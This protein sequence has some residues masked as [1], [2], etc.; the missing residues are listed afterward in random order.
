MAS[1]RIA[2][3]SGGVKLWRIDHFIVLA[4]KML[5][6]LLLYI[7]HFSESGIWLGKILFLL[8]NSPKFS[9]TRILRYTVFTA[10]PH[11]LIKRTAVCNYIGYIGRVSNVKILSYYYTEILG[12]HK[13]NKYKHCNP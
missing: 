3:N 5:A 7:S 8:P 6:N 1:Y 11:E 12:K 4:R 10:L 2:Q 9:P 13:I